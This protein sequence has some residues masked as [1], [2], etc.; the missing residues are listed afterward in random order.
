VDVTDLTRALMARDEF[1]SVISH[2]LRNPLSAVAMSA[3]VLKRTAPV[4]DSGDAL[5]ELA[6]RIDR[7]VLQMTRLI[8]DLMDLSSL[9][10][11][12]LS[13]RRHRASARQLVDDAIAANGELARRKRIEMS[14]RL[15][16]CL[17]DVIGDRDRIAQVFA[18]LIGNAIE[19]TPEAG[20]IVVGA[21]TL[22]H[23]VEFF[24]ADT[25]RGIDPAE[26][27][28]VFERH[29]RG[30][31]AGYEGAGLGL[32]IARGLVEA[33][34][35]SMRAESRPGVGS[36]FFFTLPVAPSGHEAPAA[37]PPG[38]LPTLD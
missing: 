28:R 35:G 21:E 27:E 7:A 26:M 15:P 38:R 31:G 12:R 6:A 33:H 1:L 23:Q 16:A 8:A 34:G 18:N 25:G 32:A 14:S 17:P 29:W 5:R 3:S 10:A 22:V 20:L 36:V 30:A 37:E 9:E 2:D 4:A 13:I 24:V 19:A 11:G